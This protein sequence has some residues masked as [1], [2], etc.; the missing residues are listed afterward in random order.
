VLRQYPL[1]Q[2]HRPK[3]NPAAAVIDVSG[4]IVVRSFLAVRLPAF[5]PTEQK[6]FARTCAD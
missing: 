4:W 6:S 5:H 1:G 2:S 3:K